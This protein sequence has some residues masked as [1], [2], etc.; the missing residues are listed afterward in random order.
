MFKLTTYH[1]GLDEKT[2]N[3]IVKCVKEFMPEHKPIWTCLGVAKLARDDMR[4]EID[5]TAHLG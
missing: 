5:V 1:V 3:I 4:V 2:L